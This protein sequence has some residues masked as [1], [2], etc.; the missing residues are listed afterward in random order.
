MRSW[1]EENLK[2]SLAVKARGS[3]DVRSRKK[4]LRAVLVRCFI[5]LGT[6]CAKLIKFS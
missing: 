4:N 3:V 2:E 1:S 5:D 6:F